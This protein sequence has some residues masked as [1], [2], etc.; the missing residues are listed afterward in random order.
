MASRERL[1]R[2]RRLDTAAMIEVTMKGFAKVDSAKWGAVVVVTI[3][4]LGRAVAQPEKK[5]KHLE[6]VGFIMRA[7]SPEQFARLRALPP[8]KFIARTVNGRRYY[9]YS[10]PD[11]CKCV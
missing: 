4:F 11:L 6:D 3:G 8:H 9:L 5:E 1:T 7:A 2:T 10:D